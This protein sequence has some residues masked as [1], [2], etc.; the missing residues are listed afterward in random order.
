[1]ASRDKWKRLEAIGRLKSFL[2]EYREAWGAFVG[3]ARSTVFPEGTYWMR[4][5]CGV[6]CCSS[7]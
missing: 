6:T 5:T 3:G 1:V 4:V 2:A 7:A